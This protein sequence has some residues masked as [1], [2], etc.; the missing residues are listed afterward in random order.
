MLRNSVVGAVEH[1]G[2]LLVVVAGLVGV[3][4]SSP[5]SVVDPPV[6]LAVTPS[7]VQVTTCDVLQLSAVLTDAKGKAVSIAVVWSSANTTAAQVDQ[8]G[9][10]KPGVATLA[11]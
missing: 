5:T 4:C 8:T 11:F 10:V 7:P 9:L 6:A 1:H 2:I 3:G